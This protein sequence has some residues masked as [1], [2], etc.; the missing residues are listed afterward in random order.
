LDGSFC[1]GLT[2]DGLRTTGSVH[3]ANKFEAQGAVRLLGAK[4]GGDLACVGGKFRN[5]GGNAIN[6]DGIE[7][8]GSVFLND[9]F[10]AERKVRLLGAK[11]GGNLECDGGTFHN[12]D[13]DALSAD[14]IETGGGV[15]LR[16]GFEAGGEVRLLGAKIGGNLDCDGGSFRN[17]KGNALS[18]DGVET[19]G[20]VFLRGGFEAGGEVRLL[21]AKIGGTLDCDG[22]SFRN[23]KGYALSADS[24][25]VS[26]V[27]FMREGAVVEGVLDLTRA[28][29]G[30][31]N[32]DRACWPEKRGWLVLDG[33]TYDAILGGPVDAETRLDWLGLQDPSNYSKDFWPQPYEQLAK[34]F[35]AMGHAED[36]RKVLVEKERLQRADRW[37]REE[38]QRNALLDLRQKA[39][40]DAERQT[41]TATLG[42][43]WFRRR[44]HRAWDVLVARSVGYGYRPVVALYWTLG[45]I[46]IASVFYFL[47]WRV[48]GMAPNSA[49]TLLSPSWAKAMA[50]HPDAPSRAWVEMAEG[51]HYETFNAFA[52]A[53]DVILP[54]ISFGQEAAWA[55]STAKGFWSFGTFAWFTGWLFRLLGWVITALGAAAITGIIRRE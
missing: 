26:G 2:A 45:L 14:R 41:F 30:A 24:A 49:V 42:R 33:C 22:G 37:K 38:K 5:S 17:E 20:G 50:D 32:D 27:F 8:G 9:G 28:R 6:A 34:V 12:E 36:A 18:A 55:P 7:T 47:T 4:I 46:A 52:Y 25:A 39:T 19:G 35:R 15:F 53:M 29:L 21:G 13:G 48:G 44:A 11:I 1:P 31:I 51:K 23:Q 40:T 10:E 43:L 16:G 54:V 3:L